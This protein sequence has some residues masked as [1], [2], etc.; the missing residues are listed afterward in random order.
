MLIELNNDEL[1]DLQDCLETVERLNYNPIVNEKA[2]E[3]KTKISNLIEEKILV[4]DHFYEI[5]KYLDE[6]P[7]YPKT[8]VP[9]NPADFELVEDCQMN[10]I[11]AL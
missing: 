2:N 6:I 3:L 7:V 11:N 8:K 9:G 5:Q 10:S 1:K 4:D